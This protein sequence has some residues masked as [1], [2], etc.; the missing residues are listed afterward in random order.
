MCERTALDLSMIKKRET[1]KK[2]FEMWVYFQHIHPE[3]VNRR[4]YG[5]QFLRKCL[6]LCS[7]YRHCLLPPSSLHLSLSCSLS[8][9]IIMSFC[10][11][12]SVSPF[13]PLLEIQ[14]GF[15]LYHWALP[16]DPQLLI[17][18]IPNFSL[19]TCVYWLA[20]NFKQQQKQEISFNVVEN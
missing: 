3:S 5:F 9:S 18:L 6:P 17:C 13:L 12:L 14:Q 11:S 4:H 8:D 2:A 19:E 10:L 20:L 1:K 16:T 15:L 7:Q